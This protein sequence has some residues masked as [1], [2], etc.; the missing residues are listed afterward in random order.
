MKNYREKKKAEKVGFI[1]EVAPIFN[2]DKKEPFDLDKYIN[3]NKKL[4][5]EADEKYDYM[6]KYIDEIK[7]TTEN[8]TFI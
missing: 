6:T 4:K 1:P 2:D 3:N 7:N 8:T 5:Q